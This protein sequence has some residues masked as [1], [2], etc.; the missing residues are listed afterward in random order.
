MRCLAAGSGIVLAVALAGSSAASDLLVVSAFSN[1]VLR[2]D[3]ATGAFKSVFATLRNPFGLASDHAGNVY[4]STSEG[5]VARYS[6]TGDLLDFAVAA[7]GTSVNALTVGP[8]GAVYGCVFFD[9]RVVR[10]DFGVA[11]PQVSDFVTSGSGGLDGPEGLVFGGPDGDLY[12]SSR[13]NGKVLLY[14]TSGAFVT[15][16]ATPGGNGPEGLAFGP[17]GD[18]YVATTATSTVL[19]YDPSVQDGLLGTFATPSVESG[20]GMTP[21]FGPDANLYVTLPGFGDL[22]ERFDGTSGA[23]IGTFVAGGSGGLSFPSGLVFVPEPRASYAGF[24]AALGILAIARARFRAQADSA[25]IASTT[26]ES[27]APSGSGT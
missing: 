26:W 4:V 15:V 12:V 24:A 3:G 16:Y 25:A 18:L 8:G 7:V 21:A 5:V 1:Q 27:A 17:D 23:L 19:R 13:I 10:V 11:P 6:E 14:D 2:F 9:D 22:V 20:D